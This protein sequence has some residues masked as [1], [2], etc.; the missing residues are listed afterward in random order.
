MLAGM[1]TA[2]CF[3]SVPMELVSD[4]TGE[5]SLTPHERV[6]RIVKTNI[7]LFFEGYPNRRAWASRCGGGSAVQSGRPVGAAQHPQGHA[8]LGSG[9]RDGE[10][11]IARIFSKLLEQNISSY[12]VPSTTH[13]VMLRLCLQKP[14]QI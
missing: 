1:M 2:L 7:Q 5:T 11:S 9:C 8:L 3:N 14:V 13:Y 12:K 4:T 6:V 10:L